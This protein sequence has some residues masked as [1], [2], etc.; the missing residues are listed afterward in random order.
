MIVFFFAVLFFACNTTPEIEKSDN[1]TETISDKIVRKKVGSE[2]YFIVRDSLTANDLVKYAE[3][4][5]TESELRFESTM[6]KFYFP[7]QDE[8]GTAYASVFWFEKDILPQSW[9]PI[10]KDS[11]GR[12]VQIQYNG[13]AIQNHYNK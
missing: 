9:R 1:I 13:F 8:K 7:E 4:F 10:F 6:V 5:V 3:S 2:L 12:I 11:K